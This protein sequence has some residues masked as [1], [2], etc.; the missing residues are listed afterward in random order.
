MT[1]PEIV[2]NVLFY[3]F[4][5]AAVGGALAVA[6]GRNIVRSAFA[7]LAVLL[8]VASMYAIMKADFLAAAQVLIYVGG[9]LVLIIFA[10]ML[11]H[12]IADV[13]L[14]NESAPG[15]AAFFACLCLLFALGV[16]VLSY[17][18]WERDAA[19]KAVRVRGVELSIAQYQADGRTGL[20]WGGDALEDRVVAALRGGK[21]WDRAEVE[22]QGPPPAKPVIASAPLLDGEA[23]V[24]LRGLPEGKVSW[25][26][27][28]HRGA[29]AT[30][31]AE[32]PKGGGAHVSVHRG[33]TKPL[34]RAFMGPYLFAFE[35]VSILLLAALVGAVTLARKEVRE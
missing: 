19:W 20:A 26:V 23:R 35:V 27:R 13:R 28:L 6:A 16:I 24:E 14:S 10:V 25:R 8:A 2:L 21:G 12:R 1:A 9:I 17:G 3:A 11:T 34:A 30:E 15:P 22:A 4:A 33:L 29:E 31:W 32:A 5:A 18:K 7:L